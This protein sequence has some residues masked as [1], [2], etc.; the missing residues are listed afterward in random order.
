MSQTTQHPDVCGHCN[1]VVPA[2]QGVIRRWNGAARRFA[3]KYARKNAMGVI[4]A[5]HCQAC[6]DLYTKKEI[7]R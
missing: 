6:D 5:V 1:S 3:P 2:K 4:T 7:K